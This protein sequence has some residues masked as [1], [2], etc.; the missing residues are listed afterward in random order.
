MSSSLFVLIFP[1]FIDLTS[2]YA[3]V[4]TNNFVNFESIVTLVKSENLLV[5]V[6]IFGSEC[7]FNIVLHCLGEFGVAFVD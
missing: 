6:N 5:T 2:Q 3:V 4:W 1:P 7:K